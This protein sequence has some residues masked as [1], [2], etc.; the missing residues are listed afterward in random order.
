MI[1]ELITPTLKSGS[2]LHNHEIILCRLTN[3]NLKLDFYTLIKYDSNIKQSL[4]TQNLFHRTL[5]L[6]QLYW[7]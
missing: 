5:K 3:H 4:I 2:V 7:W 1:L 6:V